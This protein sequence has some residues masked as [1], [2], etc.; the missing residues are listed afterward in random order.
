MRFIGDLFFNSSAV[1]SLFFTNQLNSIYSI[2]KPKLAFFYNPILKFHLI[3][4]YRQITLPS[5]KC[6]LNIFTPFLKV[7][8]E[9]H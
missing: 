4:K 9:V 2:E 3:F 7:N 6:F 8:T 5:F 1:L